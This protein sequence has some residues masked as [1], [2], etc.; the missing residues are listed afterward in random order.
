[1]NIIVSFFQ[2]RFKLLQQKA[3]LSVLKTGTIQGQGC[4]FNV[5]AGLGFTLY[6]F[7]CLEPFEVAVPGSMAKNGRQHERKF[8]FDMMIHLSSRRK[9]HEMYIFY[10]CVCTS[11]KIYDHEACNSLKR[12]Y[13]NSERWR[14]LFQ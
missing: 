3:T 9:R 12:Y 1:M 2:L 6:L 4:P 14:R 10:S 13:Y 5:S 7:S 8:M 11:F